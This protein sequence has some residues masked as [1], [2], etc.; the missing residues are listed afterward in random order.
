MKSKVGKD[1]LAKNEEYKDYL[2]KHISGVMSAFV[3]YFYPMRGKNCLS[4]WFSDDD[5]NDALY[6]AYLSIV[7]HDKSK[8][9]SDEFKPYRYNFFPTESELSDPEYKIKANDL[10]NK[11][12]KHHLSFNMHHPEWWGGSDMSLSCI[13][14]M[15]CDW[16]SVGNL[17][18]NK[19]ISWFESDNSSEV[20]NAMSV[21]TMA[22]VKKF[23]YEIL[24]SDI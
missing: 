21:N 22:I 23:L 14:E 6:S 2:R 8:Y 13:I 5:F 15:I 3:K 20:R 24:P 12:W 1:V 16:I 9:S 11:A 7:D 18:G 10:M 4:E 17:K 19:T